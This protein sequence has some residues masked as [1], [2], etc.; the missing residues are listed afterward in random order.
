MSFD[1]KQYLASLYP[2]ETPSWDIEVLAGGLVNLT[3][4]A[5]RTVDLTKNGSAGLILKYAPPY[6]AAL[7]ADAPFSQE[8]Q[9]GSRSIMSQTFV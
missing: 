4:R 1:F 6:V 7:G 3:V 2:D 5:Q 8:R 9:V